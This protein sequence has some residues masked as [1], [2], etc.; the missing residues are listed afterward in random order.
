M[1]RIHLKKKRK[2]LSLRHHRSDIYKFYEHKRFR[3]AFKV[4]DPPARALSVVP[5]NFGVRYVA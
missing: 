1:I 4:V 5:D 3:E 2:I